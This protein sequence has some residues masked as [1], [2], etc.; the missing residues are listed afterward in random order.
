MKTTPFAV[1]GRWRA[2]AIPATAT[3]RAVRRRAQLARSTARPRAGAGAEARAG[4]RRPRGSCAGSRRAS[5]PTASARAARASRRSGRAAARAAAPRRRCRAPT[6]RAGRA[7]APTAARAAGRR[8][9]RRRPR[10]RAPPARARLSGVR[11]ASSTTLANG[12]SALPLLDER[13]R[14]VL[15]ERVDVLEPDPDGAVL[16]RRTSPR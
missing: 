3:L 1:A 16:R 7:R 8:A 6:A 13:L 10:R 2:T 4:G 14:V 15:P 12:A 5:A 9:R 11:W